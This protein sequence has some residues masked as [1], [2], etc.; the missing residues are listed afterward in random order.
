[1]ATWVVGDVQGCWASLD[2]LLALI[3]LGSGDRIWFTGDL[4]NRGEDSLAVLR[5]AL[6]QGHRVVSV[7]GNHDLH[8]LGVAEGARR[9]APGDTLDA[10]LEAP[11]REA[12]L[13]WLRRRPFV[14]R[15]GP[16]L[17]VHAGLPPR[18]PLG[19]CLKR[20]R[21]AS[22]TLRKDGAAALLG[23]PKRA[24]WAAAFTRMRMVR[25]EDGAPDFR[26][27]G[28]PESAPIGLRPWY[29]ERRAD[30]GID[31]LLVGHWAAAGLRRAPPV[32]CLDTGCVWGGKLTALR[33][34]DG[35]LWQQDRV[36]P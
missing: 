9:L 26:W 21:K 11:D 10:I 35:R 5:W 2:A 25:A 23:H 24:A 36:R 33:I 7:V 16:L 8:L 14:H 22:R 32:W 20:A 31:A 1:M 17:L 30:P 3:P 34:E 18:W 4:V 19:T 28:T 6:R 29:V 15:E 12:L 13:G 27:K